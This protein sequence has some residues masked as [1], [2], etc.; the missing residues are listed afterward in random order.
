[1][2]DTSIYSGLR[3]LRLSLALLPCLL[4]LIGVMAYG[5]RGSLRTPVPGEVRREL[6]DPCLG[7]HWQLVADP[8]HLG[9][10]GR[11]VPVDETTAL[12]VNDT[13][14]A[15]TTA[16]GSSRA[17]LLP[18]VIRPGDR[19]T[20]EQETAVIHAQLQAV[21]LESGA[22]GDHLRVR[23]TTDKNKAM[24]IAGPVISVVATAKGLVSW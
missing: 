2:I 12:H 1:M 18:I 3:R 7:L 4:L 11:L 14:R 10:P 6:I 9:G 17:M 8:A 13:L 21:A 15:A 16:S 24:G 23:L 22:V 19:L 5:Q 20:V